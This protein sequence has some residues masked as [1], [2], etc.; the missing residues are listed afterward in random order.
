MIAEGMLE[1][2]IAFMEDENG[3]NLYHEK[4]GV[5]EDE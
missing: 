3:I 5:F 1:L 2:K 4:I